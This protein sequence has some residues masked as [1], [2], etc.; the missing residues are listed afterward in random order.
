MVWGSAWATTAWASTQGRGNTGDPFPT[1]V[2]EL[3]EIVGVIEGP[4]GPQIGSPIGGVELRNVV[5]D[6]L[7]KH[8]AI[9]TIATQGLHQHRDTSLMLHDQ[10]QHDLVEVG[11][12]IP[13]RAWRDVHDLFVRRLSVVITA[14]DLETRRIAMAARGRQPQAPGRRGGKEAGEC[15]H[16]KVVEGIES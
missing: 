4:V 9:M 6:D 13:T 12:M 2:S 8:C 7:A 1:R 15:R 10:F 14:I 16:P 3:L 11:A 5:T